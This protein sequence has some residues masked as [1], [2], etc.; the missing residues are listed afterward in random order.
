MYETDLG[1]EKEK[2]DRPLGGV[3]P[4]CRLARLRGYG[5]TDF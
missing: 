2:R 4:I 5:L 3:G 1:F